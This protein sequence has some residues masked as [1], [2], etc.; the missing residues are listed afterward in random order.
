MPVVTDLNNSFNLKTK[1]NVKPNYKID[2]NDVIPLNEI[3]VNDPANVKLVGSNFIFEEG[4]HYTFG[5]AL[6]W[7]HPWIIEPNVSMDGRNPTL[8]N[9]Q[10]YNG[11]GSMV[12]GVDFGVFSP[13]NMS[14]ECPN[15]DM[16]TLSSTGTGG[17]TL[18]ILD[19]FRGLSATNGLVC[20]TFLNVTDITTLNIISSSLVGGLGCNQG[21][22]VNGTTLGFL[23]P[24]RFAILSVLNPA[25]IALDLSN[26]K[27][28]TAYEVLN[29]VSVGIQPNSIGISG[30]PNSG[31]NSAT[32]LGTYSGCDFVG[33]IT[34]NVGILSTDRQVDFKNCAPIEE[35]TVICRII[36][37][38]D[39]II[40]MS[41]VPNGTYVDVNTTTAIS[42]GTWSTPLAK[43]YSGSVTGVMTCGTLT[44]VDVSITGKASVSRSGGAANKIGVILS[45]DAL[46]PDIS[47]GGVVE[48]STP[49]NQ[50]LDDAIIMS[51]AGGASGPIT[52]RMQVANIDASNDIKIEAGAS[53]TLRGG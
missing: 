21:V 35:S 25:F 50:T 49:S 45:F 10:T 1:N 8:S 31:N 30:L 43:R 5:G 37:D 32:L 22:V 33:P 11:V 7:P 26:A 3:V 20:Q 13:K 9:L 17:S 41:G 53:I 39:T 40:D 6:T 38:V 42:G 46:P 23:T 14:L 19:F 18:F 47:T 52:C 48:N 16:F 28:L 36:L 44:P 15:A 4:K 24:S 27:V 51:E 29:W 34:P 2:G 12:T